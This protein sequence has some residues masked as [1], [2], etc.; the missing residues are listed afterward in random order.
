[1]PTV[2]NLPQVKGL[3]VTETADFI[4]YGLG[5]FAFV[6]LLNEFKKHFYE[7]TDEIE[8]KRKEKK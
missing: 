6:Y 7:V 2:S 8:A 4:F 5:I 1:M 3:N